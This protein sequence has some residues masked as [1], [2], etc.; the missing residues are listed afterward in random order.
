MFGLGTTEIV[1][2]LLIA[3]LIL[4]PTELPKVAKSL[5][6][7]VASLR[8]ATE[9]LKETVEEDKDLK[10]IKDTFQEAADTIRG[11]V[12][13]DEMFDKVFPEG[14]QPEKDLEQD[15]ESLE[16]DEVS[17]DD[18]FPDDEPGEQVGSDAAP[19]KTGTGTSEKQS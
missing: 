3:L 1:I 14:D 13:Y 10:M 2:I 18:I 17:Y 19:D 11:Q 4:G 6:K 9:E 15:T 16:D 7:G 12:D 5:G 8:R